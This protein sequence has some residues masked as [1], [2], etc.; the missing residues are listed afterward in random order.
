MLGDLTKQLFLREKNLVS[1]FEVP[2]KES[3]ILIE[4][5]KDKKKISILIKKS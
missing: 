2:L 3:S 5:I 4:N 1:I